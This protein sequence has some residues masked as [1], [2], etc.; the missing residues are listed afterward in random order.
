MTAASTLPARVRERSADRALDEPSGWRLGRRA[1]KV[2]L[3]AHVLMSVGWFGIAVVVLVGAV[4]AMTTGDASLTR[5]LHRFLELAPWVSIPAGV[6]AAATGVVLSLGTRYGL[7]RFWWVV[8]KIA[9][10][11]AV[12]VT[13]AVVIERMAQQAVVTGS[14]PGPLRDGAIAHVVVLVLATVL[15]V[16]KPFGRTPRGQRRSV[17]SARAS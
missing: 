16:F 2:A 9:I 12:V 13:D 3:T 7:V 8:I 4:A 1:R 10:T 15:S 14:S 5:A 11:V 17:S 6:L